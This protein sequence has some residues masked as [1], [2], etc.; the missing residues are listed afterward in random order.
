MA[1]PIPTSTSE[2]RQRLSDPLYRNSFFIILS[3]IA[4]SG[5]GFFFWT[6]AARL[7]PK[8]EIG[9][10]T[11]LISSMGLILMIS[12]LGMD[13]YI[14]RFSPEGDR[15][16]IAATA[17]FATTLIAMAVSI[18]FVL[19]TPIWAPALHP[20]PYL[21]LVFP[22][23]IIAQSML[24]TI[25]TVFLSM[26][27]GDYHFLQ[28]L[29][30]GLRI[31]LLLPL[32]FLGALGIFSSVG[33]ATYITVCVSAAILIKKGI[34]L[35]RW[36]LNILRESFHFSAGNYLAGLIGS[37]PAL[38]FP[39]LVL[40][41]RGPE[42]A[43]GYYIVYAIASLLFVIP[44]AFN[45]S[46]FV[47]GSHGTDLRNTGMKTIR[48]SFLLLLPCILLVILFG[49]RILGFIGP[50]YIEGY[51][52]LVFMALAAPF[53]GGTGFF[54]NIKRIRQE[55]RTLILYNALIAFLLLF[56]GYLLLSMYGITG[57]GTAW[58]ITYG[59][60]CAIIAFSH[61]RKSLTV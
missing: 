1:L 45:T 36:D 26:R 41:L 7:Y 29:I 58:F 39:V 24:S 56:S 3:S 48:A 20:V 2:L 55:I 51:L 60:T 53:I 23:F 44:G 11:A 25:G 61:Y 6:I 32:V 9:I 57:L 42:D 59:F 13:Q 21:L 19:G 22:L 10:A 43:A 34:S 8:G 18:A 5:F 40:N 15:G 38:L 54:L 27:H 30:I 17:L 16:R 4:T 47:E 14:I 49:S 50:G 33:I 37:T 12:R 35:G 31:P 46:M 28:T 52:A